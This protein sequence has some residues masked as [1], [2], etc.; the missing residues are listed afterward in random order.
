MTT[1]ELSAL[2]HLWLIDLDGTI[3]KHNGHLDG[4]DAL[5]PGVQAFWNAIPAHDMII[6]VSARPPAFRAS[7]LAVLDAQGLRYDDAIFGA[8][9]GERVLINDIKPRGLQTAIAVNLPRDTGLAGLRV[10]AADD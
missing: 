3:L 7:S 6:I 9:H 8:P 2:R 10:Q 5:L 4:Q 1:I